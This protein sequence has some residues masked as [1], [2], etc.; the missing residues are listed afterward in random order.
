MKTTQMQDT[1]CNAIVSTVPVD[2]VE[3]IVVDAVSDTPHYSE[4]TGSTK[5]FNDKLGYGFITICDGNDKGKDI[6]VHHSGINPL[7]SNYKTL[8]KGEYIQFNIVNG[9]NGLQAIDVT[10]IKGG[11]LMCDYVTSKRLVSIDVPVFTEEY[12]VQQ[13]T[14]SWQTVAKK[15]KQVFQGSPTIGAKP[16]QQ[17]TRV[18]NQKY[19]KN[20][21]GA[22]KKPALPPL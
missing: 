7:N 5:W 13:P 14:N 2:V 18:P 19:T 6:F 21:T 3:H 22:G 12:H 16:R 17:T 1:N 9:I 10:G 11:P 20:T 8:R 15:Q 4:F